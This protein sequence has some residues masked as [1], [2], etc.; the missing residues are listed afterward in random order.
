MMST[1]ID[2]IKNFKH[3][4]KVTCYEAISMV[5]VELKSDYVYTDTGLS[6]KLF[7]DNQSA[8]H[9][10]N[11]VNTTMVLRAGLV[12]GKVPP[13]TVCPF[14]N[15]CPYAKNNSCGHLG[16]GHTVA[17]SCGAARAFACDPK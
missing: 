12:N 11:V 16:V 3:V 7:D 5:L 2:F 4:N 17:Y 15:K 13:N 14:R 9:G 10:A 8:L 6:H 1:L